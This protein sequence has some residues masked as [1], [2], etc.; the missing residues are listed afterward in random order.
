MDAFHG[1]RV[2]VMGLGRFGGGVGVT[3]WLAA[4][5]AKVLVTDIEPAGKLQASIEAIQPLVDA[6]QVTLRL[7][8]HRVEDF[9]GCDVVVANPAV[10]RPWENVYLQAAEKAGAKITTEIG[11]SVSRLDPSRLVCITGSAG[12]STTSALIAHILQRAGERVRLGGNIGGSL[13]ETG[14][15]EEAEGR[16]GTGG[17]PV[18][19]GGEG[20][21]ASP[22]TVLEL[23]SFQLYW[24]GREM[25]GPKPRVAC[26]TNI[27]DN[28]LDWHVT[29]EHYVQSKQVILAG[30]A[31]G[32]HAV[33]G[34][35]VREWATAPG[36]T[37]RVIAADAKVGTLA[38]PGSHNQRNA[39]MACAAVA[40]L[41]VSGLSESKAAA[42]AAD[43]PGLPHRLQL[44]AR[45]R[46]VACYNDSKA[47]TPEATLLAVRALHESGV[48]VHLIAGGYDKHADLSSVAALAREGVRL[49]TIGATGPVI[50]ASAGGKATECGTL[51][52]AVRAAVNAAREGEA[53][54]LSPACASWDQFSNYEE[55]G[56]QF[57]AL[58][59]GHGA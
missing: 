12:K 2:T 8:E 29:F 15:A 53:L 34:E 7:G 26:V 40:A 32:S 30:Q 54:L 17:T 10:P 55:R 6:G 52:V 51:E 45:V 57:A 44:V 36:V 59:R 25:G 11:L 41:G 49:Y 14:S 24:L 27:A 3:R 35:N 42:L 19:R 46:G 20:K 23:S 9:T 56:E 37:R 50:A 31:L 33:L 13:L 28:H 1:Q 5:G 4:R 43:Y 39:A 48:R 16:V 22:W 47:T 38:I 18:P 58:V 21:T